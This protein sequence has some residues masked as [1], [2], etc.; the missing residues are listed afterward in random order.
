[1][2]WL[3]SLALLLVSCSLAAAADWPQWLGPDR[4]GASKEV[5]APW[6]KVPRVLWR[7]R[8][9]EGHSSPVVAGG[10]VVLHTKV[11]DKSEEELTAYDARTGKRLWHTAY[12]RGSFSSVF[13]NGPR[14][15]PAI[16]ADRIYTNGVTGILGCF[17]AGTGDK[18]WQVDTLAKFKAANLKFGVSC[19]P[20]VAGD[21]VLV[22]VG[23]KGASVVAFGKD[24]GDVVWKSLDDRA[25]YSSPIALGRGKER[26]VVF[27]TEQGLRSL[28][29]SD[30]SLFWKFRMIDFL[31]ES[32]TT[33]VYVGDLVVAGSVTYG[34][35]GLRL[36][37]EDGKPAAAEEW[38]N[39]V[40]TC[41]FSTPVPVGKD[42][43]MV[44][45]ALSLTAPQATLRCVE[46]KSGKERW[47][48]AKVGKYHAALLRT[49]DDKLLMLEDNGDLV[50]ID[51]SP[52]GYRELSR[53]KVCGDTWDHPALSNGRL[54]LRDEQEFI[55]LQL[56]E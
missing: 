11:K 2:T 46:A 5:V 54:Y 12:A 33:P 9:G 29:P 51:P 1:M 15:T 3:R 55:C 21:K 22:N 39:G 47:H 8:V 48:K 36:K 44:T 34:S 4:N 49:G 40:L 38:K 16:V 6:K 24:K 41:Y 37:T 42:L 28:S 52:N 45:G 26:Q 30:G 14:G 17:D 23:A 53:S 18:V 35:V 43:Y 32:A 31:S 10:R 19:S 27:V 56:G 25:S 20:L 13:G 50:L 7:H